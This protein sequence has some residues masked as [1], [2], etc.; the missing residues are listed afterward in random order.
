[1]QLCEPLYHCGVIVG[2]EQAFLLVKR[3]DIRHILLTQSK[4]EHIDILLHALFMSGLRDNHN[5]ALYKKPERCL[6]GALSVSAAYFAQYGIGKEILSTL[7]EGPQLSCC[8][9]Y[10]SIYS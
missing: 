10:F 6:G 7:C 1:M 2:E 5:S 9:P 3:P 4:V 8:T